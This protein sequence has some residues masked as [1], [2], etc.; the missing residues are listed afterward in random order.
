MPK[1]KSDSVLV[2]FI[3]HSLI[4]YSVDKKTQWWNDHN[5]ESVTS[6]VIG[7]C[8]NIT[9]NQIN[10]FCAVS[11]IAANYVM[12]AVIGLIMVCF[13]ERKLFVLKNVI[14]QT[15]LHKFIR[16]KYVLA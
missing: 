9:T 12:C 14:N 8:L 4:H 16:V 10:Y 6:F 7:Q 2:R 1:L 3:A 5:I 11:K 15:S 13:H